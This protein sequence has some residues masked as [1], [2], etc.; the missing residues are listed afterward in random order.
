MGFFGSKQPAKQQVAKEEVISATEAVFDEQFRQEL[1]QISRQH[2]QEILNSSTVDLKQDIDNSMRQVAADLKEYM[3]K[4]LD[5]TISQVNNSITNQ[6][7]ERINEYSRLAHEAQ[8]QASQGFNR[9]TQLIQEKYQQLAT[10][11]QQVIASQEVAMITVFQ[12]NKSRI[13]AIQ[14]EQEKVLRSL[15]E[16]AQVSRQQSHQLNQAMQKNISDQSAI[17]SNIYQENIARVSEARNAQA[18]TLATL[19]HSIEAL[20][21]QHQQLR[22]LL[23]KSIAEQKARLTEAIN[24]NMA[25]I[26]EHYLVGA[27]GEQSD[28]NAQLPSILEQL[29]QN[30]QAMT[31]DMKL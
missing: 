8:E 18:T 26:I 27:L 25:S 1:R 24:E 7:N 2:F 4:Q 11:L 16:S 14:N 29:E 22:Q 28:L 15:S 13:A 19:G 3:I 31:D 21:Q 6:L 23:E 17:L 20:E 5:L 9:N 30:K 12:D 10:N